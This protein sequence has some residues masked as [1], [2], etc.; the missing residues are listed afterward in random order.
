MK[1]EM[2][3]HP[4][5]DPHQNEIYGKSTED[6][7]VKTPE[8][9]LNVLGI[10]KKAIYTKDSSLIKDFECSTDFARQRVLAHG[11]DAVLWDSWFLSNGARVIA[12]LKEYGKFDESIFA[13][14]LLNKHSKYKVRPLLVWG[15]LGILVRLQSKVARLVNI[16]ED[17]SLGFDDEPPKKTIED[18]LGYCI[19]GYLLT[20]R[21]TESK[22]GRD[23]T[24]NH[25]TEVLQP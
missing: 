25:K 4:D 14:F 6:L 19:L 13:M 7:L 2:N 1:E 11:T 17:T 24:P 23:E 3:G 20:K 21:L 16:T 8:D 10:M 5:P 18:I 9:V 15:E 12:L 22:N